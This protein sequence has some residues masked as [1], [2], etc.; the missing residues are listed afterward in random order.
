MRLTAI[1]EPWSIGDGAYEPWERHQVVNVALELS[2]TGLELRPA[3][4]PEELSHLGGPL[5]RCCATV[6]RT[7]TTEHPPLVALT[8]NG[9]RCYCWP[10]DLTDIHPGARLGGVTHLVVDTYLLAD[11]LAA[12]RAGSEALAGQDLLQ[13]LH[14]F[15][16]ERLWRVR[17]PERFIARD[18][19][20]LGSPT[21]VTW[22]E[23][24]P[25]SLS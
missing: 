16:V 10:R 5:Y 24:P 25:E 7:Y 23:F 17:I 11:A 1:F 15:R 18:E 9:F 21:W 22:G 6:V 3:T 20:G 4:S 14:A 12:A 19:R 8:A 13:L 2:A